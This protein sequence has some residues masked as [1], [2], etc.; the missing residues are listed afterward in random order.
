MAN[1]FF[2]SL[3]GP[4][5]CLA[6]CAAPPEPGTLVPL[7]FSDSVS[8]GTREIREVG[9]IGKPMSGG[10]GEVGAEGPPQL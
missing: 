7:S 5:I 1:S 9:S 4:K 10:A 3:F 6:G 8:P 2:F